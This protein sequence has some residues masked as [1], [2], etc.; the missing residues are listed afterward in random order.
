MM[1]S[2]QL[3]S[4]VQLFATPWTAGRQAPLSMRFSGQ[5]HWSELPVPS[6]RDL[7]NPVIEPRSPAMHETQVQFLGWSFPCGSAGKESACNAGNL[8]ST[9]VEIGRASCRERV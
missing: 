7:P 4:H 8:G 9:Q 2:V 6:P 3:L 1:S 5:E